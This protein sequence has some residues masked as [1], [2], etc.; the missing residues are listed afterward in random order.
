ML[1]SENYRAQNRHL[2]ESPSFGITSRHWIDAV[3]K[4]REEY[5]A[6]SILDYG[7]GKGLLKAA[8]GDIVA[9][10][11]PA[12]EGKDTIPSPADLVVCIDVLEHIEPECI[13]SVLIDLRRC[14]KKA[15]LMTIAT[16]PAKRILSDGRNA[17]LIQKPYTW[18]LGMLAQQFKIRSFQNRNTDIVLV[19][20]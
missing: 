20:E 4:L 3:Q 19:L 6:S 17:H 15:A 1:I 18:W 14:T 5:S 10:Y 9:E 12:I 16:R 11:D 2:H 7:C 8:L 13:A